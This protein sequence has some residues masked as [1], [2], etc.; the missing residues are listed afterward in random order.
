MNTY[1][2]V[3]EFL[4]RFSDLRQGSAI[5]SLA[6]I[7]S[8]SVFVTNF[9]LHHPVV[10]EF[11]ADPS[12]EFDVV[13]SEATLT[14]AFMGFGQHF[15]APVIG[16][17]PLGATMGV[18]NMVGTPYP[19][20]YIPHVFLSYTDRMTFPQRMVNLIVTMFERTASYI[21]MNYHREIYE[22]AFPG[23]NKPSLDDVLKNVSLVL[24]NQ[25]FSTSMPRPYVPN[26]IEIGGIH[27]N[28]NA[29]NPLPTDIQD[30]IDGAEHGVVYFSLGGNIRSSELPEDI[31]DI[32]VRVL[33]SLKQRVMWKFELSDLA[34]KP[35]NLLIRKWFPQ[36]DV[37][38]HPNIKLLVTHGG[39]LSTSEAIYHGVPMVTIP[40]FADQSLN[41]ERARSLGFGVTLKYSNLTES[42]F[43]WALN[44]ALNVPSYKISAQETSQRFRDQ[45]IPPLELAVYW[46]EY[47]AR[48][49]GAPHMHSAG[50]E[51]S[52]L[53]YH[54]VDTISVLI[55]MVL[56]SWYLTWLAAVW[57]CCRGRSKGSIVKTPVTT[58]KEK[59]I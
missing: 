19:I 54:C 5:E 20:S 22:R 57:L 10:Q 59:K 27:I 47:V 35:K 53:A 50:Q 32:I 31:R 41:A 15:N 48:Y 46:V 21:I 16:F 28:R 4:T 44:E 14:Q 24:I 9:T 37:L 49:K 30:F 36:D 11:L 13:I 1:I 26:M 6:Q 23:I 33:G 43:S 39:M 38:A 29:P 52:F 51:L 2:T 58:Q 34:D 25:H 42:S 56:L 12:E 8:L 7:F 55:A 18:T 3:A 40:F 17:S 45:P